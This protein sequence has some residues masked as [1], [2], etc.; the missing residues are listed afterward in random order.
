MKA[1]D[2]QIAG[3]HYRAKGDK[4]QHWDLATMFQWDPFQYQVTKYVMRWKDKHA[5]HAERVQD[6]KKARHFL[7]KYIEEAEKWDPRGTGEIK[8]RTTDPVTPLKP[9][10]P[11]YVYPEVL[12][13]G[14]TRTVPD[15][16]FVEVNTDWQCEGWYGD[17]TQLYRCKHCR[18]LFRT[19]DV[20]RAIELHGACPKSRGYVNQD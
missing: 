19:A 9:G 12:D 14:D 18:S 11:I 15:P 16:G 17:Q 13:Q 6:L 2:H 5:T 8:V 1:N 7:D 20:D 4:L 3:N 10:E